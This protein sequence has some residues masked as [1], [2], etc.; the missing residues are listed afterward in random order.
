[1]LLE[2]EGITTLS[3]EEADK[4]SAEQVRFLTAVPTPQDTI[5]FAMAVCAPYTALS[6]YKY[7]VHN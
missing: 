5:H 6:K 1:M 4:L 7:K 2:E 3:K